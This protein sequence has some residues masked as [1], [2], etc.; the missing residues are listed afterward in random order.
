MEGRGQLRE[1]TKLCSWRCPLPALLGSAAF[2]G[3]AARLPR[4][5]WGKEL[6]QKDLAKITGQESEQRVQE[7]VL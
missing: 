2:R 6:K 5:L 4:G 1:G 7:W 3:A